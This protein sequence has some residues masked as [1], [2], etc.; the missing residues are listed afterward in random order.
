[1]AVDDV[2]VVGF[3]VIGVGLVDFGVIV[4]ELDSSSG[5]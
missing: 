4:L 1:M 3:E 2:V 5:G